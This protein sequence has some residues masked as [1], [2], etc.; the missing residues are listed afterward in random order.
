[1]SNG[2]LPELLIRA[3]VWGGSHGGSPDEVSAF[4]RPLFGCAGCPNDCDAQ[5]WWQTYLWAH[6]TGI[7]CSLETMDYCLRFTRWVESPV[8]QSGG[9]EGEM[10]RS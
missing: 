7:P 10:E 9:L 1:M 6:Q 3:K 8:P 5:T 2:L 4:A